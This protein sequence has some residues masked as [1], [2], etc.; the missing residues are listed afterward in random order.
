MRMP[1]VLAVA[2]SVALLSLLKV[3]AADPLSVRQLDEVT[4][5]VGWTYDHG[6]PAPAY[7]ELSL[8]SSATVTNPSANS[9]TYHVVPVTR[10][11]PYDFSQPIES[12]SVR[13]TEVNG[14]LMSDGY[15][16]LSPGSQTQVGYRLIC[17]EPDQGTW[18]K[19]A[20]EVWYNVTVDTSNVSG[21]EWY[22][23][24]ISTGQ[25]QIH[26]YITVSNK[27]IEVAVYDENQGTVQ[28]VSGSLHNLKVLIPVEQLQR[29][30]NELGGDYTVTISVSLVDS[31]GN[32]VESANASADVTTDSNGNVVVNTGPTA[33]I[34]TETVNGQTRQ[35]LT[36]GV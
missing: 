34:V 9:K 7:Q 4:C 25:E 29:L 28:R 8:T 13:L 36:I 11:P 26:E 20:P 6:A 15:L 27:G 21:Q 10:K 2:L 17:R 18:K 32:T 5:E 3:S 33:L 19:I 22:Q 12:G 31:S 24:T 16:A 35:F 23:A 1:R 14:M 30:R